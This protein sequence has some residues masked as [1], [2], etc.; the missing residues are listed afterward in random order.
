MIILQIK[1][2]MRRKKF[3][4]ALELIEQI[5][6]N[7]RTSEIFLLKGI[8]IQ[9]SENLKFNLNEAEYSFKKAIELDSN[10]IEAKIEL[11]WFYFN[12]LDQSKEADKEF[13]DA[14]EII[15]S[16]LSELVE[17][18]MKINLESS[19]YFDANQFITDYTSL[20]LKEEKL[21]ELFAENE[22]LR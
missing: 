11:G 1:E 8:C 22:S 19:T 2:S 21:K 18:F 9:L 17:G 16:K 10:N 7:F 12:V 15:K 5:P 4:E 13:G 14:L 3:D 20:I 6:E